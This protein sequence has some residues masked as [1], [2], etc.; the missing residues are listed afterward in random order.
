MQSGC[1]SSQRLAKYKKYRRHYAD[2]ISVRSF[3]LESI[4]VSADH[5]PKM[6]PCVPAF[7]LS[8][9]IIVVSAFTS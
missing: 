1:Y 2:E 9:C 3:A 6:I 5:M 8:A 7:T 4:L